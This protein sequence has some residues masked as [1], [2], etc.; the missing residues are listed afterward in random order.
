MDVTT[1]YSPWMTEEMKSAMERGLAEK[2]AAEAKGKII[3]EVAFM[4]VD[5]D[6][7]DGDDQWVL[8]SKRFRNLEKQSPASAPGRP[9]ARRM[10]PFRPCTRA[11]AKKL[12]VTTSARMAT[13]NE[14][15][16][17]NEN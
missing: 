8:S 7:D 6:E 11:Y 1:K 13:C 10:S 2:Q 14:G 5:P 12:S 15:Y 3:Y 16:A 17:A 9:K 4:G